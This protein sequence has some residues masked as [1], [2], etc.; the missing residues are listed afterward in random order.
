[1][2]RLK[3]C[4][5]VD[6]T[7]GSPHRHS[8][9]L[10]S[11]LAAMPAAAHSGSPAATKQ[12]SFSDLLAPPPS[13]QEQMRICLGTGFLLPR[14]RFLHAPGQQLLCS[15]HNNGIHNA[16]RNRLQGS[17]SNLVC[18]SPESSAQGESPVDAAYAPW[19]VPSPSTTT[20]VC[21]T[22]APSYTMCTV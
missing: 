6:A 9:L 8:R 11:G 12:N 14:R 4:T 3:A 5:A 21:S 18:S 15:L 20:V 7:P 2:S 13:Q 1:V 17:I 22:L 16:S 19:F 10:G